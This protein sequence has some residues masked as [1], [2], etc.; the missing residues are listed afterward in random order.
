MRVTEVVLF[1]MNVVRF[2][3]GGKLL[4][5]VNC[6]KNAGLETLNSIVWI[7][8]KLH[9]EFWDSVDGAVSLITTGDGWIFIDPENWA[10]SHPLGLE[11]DIVYGMVVGTPG[12]AN[13]LPWI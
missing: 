4:P 10:G 11:A 6:G 3:F 7:S 1:L 2:I 5:G 9:T 8:E 13:K 12:F